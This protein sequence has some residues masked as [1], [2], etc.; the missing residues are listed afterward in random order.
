MEHSELLSFKYIR[1]IKF[2]MCLCW[3]QD[4]VSLYVHIMNT[5]YS[6]VFMLYSLNKGTE[7][8]INNSDKNMGSNMSV[9][10]IVG[11]FG[12]LGGERNLNVG[13]N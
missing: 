8:R 1:N 13:Q 6:G 3:T 9:A 12:G 2:S 10:I 4:T 11:G 5:K 7:N